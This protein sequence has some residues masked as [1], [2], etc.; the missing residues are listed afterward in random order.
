MT[1]YYIIILQ[2]WHTGQLAYTF[3]QVHL[4][5]PRHCF[6]EFIISS[7]LGKN[8]NYA[9]VDRKTANVI[10]DIDIIIDLND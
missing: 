3:I 7:I 9:T 6:S 1:Y 5:S 8:V 2:V 4:Y 10:I